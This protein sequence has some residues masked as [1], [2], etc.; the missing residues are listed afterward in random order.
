MVAEQTSQNSPRRK[1]AAT[2]IARILLITILLV[3]SL[4]YAV[5]DVEWGKLWGA[6]TEANLF[7]TFMVA[8]VV[9]L[10]HIARAERWRFFI[11]DGRKIHLMNAFSAT[12]IG[13]FMNNI[14]PR[15]GEFV[16]PYT[17]ARREGH[18]TSSLLATVVV[19]RILDG[20]TLLVILVGIIVI[21]GDELAEL[22]R[23][24]DGLRNLT[25]TDLIVRLAIPVGA[26][27]LLLVLALGTRLGDWLVQLIRKV[28]P[29]KFGE[30][31]EHL[32]EEFRAGAKFSGG[33]RGLLAVI[34][35]SG[36]IWLG[37]ILSLHCGVLA[38]GLNESFGLDFGDSTV[39]LGITAIG[40][41]VAPTPGGFGVF[42]TF[43]RV[44]LVSL[45]GVPVEQAVAFAFVVHFAQYAASMIVGALMILREGVSLKSAFGAE[46]A[47]EE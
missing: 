26:V 30:K 18:S 36:I 23:Q 3:G 28:L 40:V 8:V 37:Y 4:W 46:K 39:L 45:Y 47:F 2:Q 33:W 43:C 12:V 10:A 11:A 35:W 19:E 44:T 32:F 6:I 20:I 27:V 25:P 16:R 5:R 13:Y 34:F 38:F 42:H 14:I 17:L 21:A 29:E 31:I 9:M 22:L 7:W 1:N 41:A 24:I 15:S